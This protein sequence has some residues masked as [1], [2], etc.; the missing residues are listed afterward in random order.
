MEAHAY[1]N[2]RSIKLL[3]K[4]WMGSGIICPIFRKREKDKAKD[5]GGITLLVT[6]YKVYA[7]I[8]NERVK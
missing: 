1:G 3:N 7:S 6:P 8:L 5:Y 4:I 2:R